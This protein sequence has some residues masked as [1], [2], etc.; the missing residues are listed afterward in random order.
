MNRLG[1]LRCSFVEEASQSLSFSVSL[2]QCL[3]KV[4]FLLLEVSRNLAQLFLRLLKVV[5]HPLKVC[6][7]VVQRLDLG[8]LG[9]AQLSPVL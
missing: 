4:H 9:I 3:L 7:F 2:I 6:Q 5:R 8:A 1:L